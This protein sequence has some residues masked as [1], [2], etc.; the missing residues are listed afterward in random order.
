MKLVLSAIGYIAAPRNGDG[1]RPSPLR[2]LDMEMVAD[3]L[4]C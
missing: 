1:Q 4:H 3:R 2:G